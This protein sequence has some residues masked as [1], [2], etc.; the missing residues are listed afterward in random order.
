MWDSKYENEE[1]LKSQKVMFLKLEI[2]F[3]FLFKEIDI[4]KH[5]ISTAYGI[6]LSWHSD[7]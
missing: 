6:E 3:I 1:Y 4:Y 7:I 5:K 2:A